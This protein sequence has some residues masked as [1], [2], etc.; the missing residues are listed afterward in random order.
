MKKNQIIINVK[1]FGRE[2]NDETVAYPEFAIDAP[3]EMHPGDI[4]GILQVAYIQS[5]MLFLATHPKECIDCPGYIFHK[6]I[7][8]A[9]N[10]A[11]K[12]HKPK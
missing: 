12:P 1:D 5:A 2:E 6:D 4:A 10:K 3:E 11:K 7:L 8:D 9:M